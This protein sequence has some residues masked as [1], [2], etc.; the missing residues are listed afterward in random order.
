MIE[1][2]QL[3][4][5][6]DNDYRQHKKYINGVFKSKEEILRIA[7]SEGRTKIYRVL[8]FG[9]GTQ[10][11]HLL[12]AHL[13]GEVKYDWIVFSDTGAEP[14]FIH[15][16]VAWWQ[17]R[18]KEVGNTTPFIITHHN[19]MH[20][21]LEEMLMRYI[22]TD[23]QR[24][25][26]P[27]YFNKVTEDGEIVK[28]GLMP[29]QCT[30]DFKIIPV[31][32]ATRNRIKQELGLRS[33]QPMPKHIG[34]VMDIGFSYDEIN[35]VGGFVSHQSKY[36]YLA[37]PLIEQ[38]KTTADSIKFLEENKFPSKR[39]RCYFCPFNCSGDRARDIG[40]DWQEIIDLEPIS[41][42]KACYFDRELRKVQATGR[43]NMQSIPYFHFSRTA[44]TEVYATEYVLLK[45][46][47]RH[48]IEK[49]EAEW[50]KFISEK[51]GKIIAS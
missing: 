47:Y 25:Q 5:L 45:N 18:Q 15:D 20:G 40:M 3:E 49:W 27:L 7:E 32:Q 29:R 30:G 9:G 34:I 10:S 1:G 37:Y 23:Y 8:S 2:K 17:E 13:R 36:I 38:G 11:S 28:G 22:F 51:Y 19:S 31:Q 44:L 24:F 14:Q 21:G 46:K 35:R 43:K 33:R 16:Q 39:S 48:H 50:R 4:L 12:E 6:Q 42:L 41:F 26:M